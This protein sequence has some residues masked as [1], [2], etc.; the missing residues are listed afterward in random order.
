MVMT[1]CVVEAFNFFT[2][3]FSP[4]QLYEESILTI[5]LYGIKNCDTIKKARNWLAQHQL[6]YQFIDHR[7]DGLDPA[8]LK[9]W[10]DQLGWEAVLNK[11]GTTYRTLSAEQKESLDAD[12]AF[13]LLIAQP[14]MIKRPL[15]A[16]NGEL[17][18]GFNDAAYTEL[19]LK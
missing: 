18:L 16:A 6:A 19:L 1:P 2:A 13:E 4:F 14:A 8:Q 5:K 11:R 9:S 10:L 12:S 7:A 3:T 15:L 17:L